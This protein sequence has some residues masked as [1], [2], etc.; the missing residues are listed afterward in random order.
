MNML[1][2]ALFQ[3]LTAGSYPTPWVLSVA[4]DFALWGSWLSAGVVTLA[5]WRQPDDRAWL[6]VVAAA[7]GL[8]SLLAHSIAM[9]LDVP[10]PFVLGL[11]PAY[12][13]HAG[14][15][16]LP[17]THASVMFMVALAFALR[18]SLRW[19]CAPLLVLAAVTGWARVYVGVH[20]PL[21]IVAGLLLGGLVAGALRSAQW[22]AHRFL[23]FPTSQAGRSRDMENAATAVTTR[24]STPTSTPIPPRRQ[25]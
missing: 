3:W 13:A 23:S 15:G 21:D 18:P 9:S 16:S 25:P 2:V 17:S 19:L 20:F 12:I 5:L 24:T 7:A 4:S 14:R 10:R 6:F 8:T 1:N 22:L 11:A